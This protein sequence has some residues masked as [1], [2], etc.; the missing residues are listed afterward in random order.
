M[1]IDRRQFVEAEGPATGS[2]ASPAVVPRALPTMH[3]S[4]P[5]ALETL[6]AGS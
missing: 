3:Q 2:V 6:N 1:F 5:E 4:R